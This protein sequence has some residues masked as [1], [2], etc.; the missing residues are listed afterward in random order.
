MR[1]ILD[2]PY[3]SQIED[4]K[5]EEWKLHSCGIVSLA[6]TLA[7]LSNNKTDL[8]NLIDQGVAIGG[9]SSGKWVHEALVRLSRNHGLN[10][11]AQEFRSVEVVGDAFTVSSHQEDL[12]KFGLNKIRKSIENNVPVIVSVS[13]GFGSNESAHTVLI[14]GYDTEGDVIKSFYINDPDTRGGEQNKVEVSIDKFLKYWRLFA[15]FFEK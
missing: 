4:V 3:Y 5:R 11:Y 2:V 12:I 7:F 8:D 10:A 6:M 13:A 9:H 14:V 15:I 1:K